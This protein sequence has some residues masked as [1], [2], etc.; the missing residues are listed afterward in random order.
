MI[1]NI[2]CAL[3]VIPQMFIVSPFLQEKEARSFFRQILA[4]LHYVHESGL[5]HRD[6]KPVSTTDMSLYLS[7]ISPLNVL[8][9]I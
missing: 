6:L 7:S 5:I 9:Y 4:A 2:K 3:C 1:M 8:A